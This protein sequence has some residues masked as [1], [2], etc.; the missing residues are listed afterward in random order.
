[1]SAEPGAGPIWRDGAFSADEWARFDPAVGLPP[2]ST[3]L[4]VKQLDFLAGRDRFLAHAGPLGVEIAAGEPVDVL[5][6]FLSRLA[7]IAIEF[8]RFSDGR[9]YTAARLLRERLGF[10]GEL[11][12]VGDVLADQISLMRR[13]GIDSFQVT[14]A[15]TRAALADGRLA[16]VRR[17]YQPLPGDAPPPAGTR[18]WLRLPGRPNAIGRSAR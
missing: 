18:P 13:C 2:P 4:L 7:L 17:Y 1:L 8:P 9:G 12:A 6:P 15:P 5:K 14:H 11:R 16:E 10:R 3:P